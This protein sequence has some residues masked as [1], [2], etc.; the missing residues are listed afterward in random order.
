MLFFLFFTYNRLN[1][2]TSKT[3]LK[4]LEVNSKKPLGKTRMKILNLQLIRK[5]RSMNT[6]KMSRNEFQN[7]KFGVAMNAKFETLVE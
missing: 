3:K 1:R 7:T 4:G 2:N 6:S 5:E